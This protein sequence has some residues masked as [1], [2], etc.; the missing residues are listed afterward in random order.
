VTPE[1]SVVV[2]CYKA[3]ETAIDFVARLKEA[4]SAVTP[5]WELV[6]VGNYNKG[7]STDSTP[8]VVR[9]LAAEDSRVVAVTLEKEGW[10]GWDAR[11]GLARARGRYVAFIDGD[12]QMPP[13]DVVRVFTTIRDSD[14]DMVTT[15]RVQRGDGSFR[16][17]QS[18]GYNAIF[19]CL[20][21]G[22][23]VRDVNSKPKI[24]R[25]ELF[26]KLA[27]T[28]DDW[29]LDA[30]IVI[31]V[32][33]LKARVGQIPTVFRSSVARSS[34]VKLTAIWEFVMNLLRA[35]IREFFLRS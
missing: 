24:F 13:E 2:L 21:P 5:D 8:A 29:F 12:N 3:R 17:F 7:D 25:R 14:F 1:L 10:M 15:Y 31:Q 27:L 32:R 11:T 19:N 18:F 4:L 34:M 35:R 26:D 16:L 20:F 30:E 6:L 23:G 9:Q 22:S 33:R 28:S